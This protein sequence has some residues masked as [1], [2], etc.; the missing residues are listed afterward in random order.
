MQILSHRNP[1][2]NICRER[3]LGRETAGEQSESGVCLSHGE[4]LLS[5]NRPRIDALLQNGCLRQMSFR[6]CE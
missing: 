3:R 5:N 6:Y 4:A 1:R 2:N